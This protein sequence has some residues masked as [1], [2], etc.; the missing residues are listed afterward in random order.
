MGNEVL[1]KT[2]ARIGTGLR[3]LFLI[4]QSGISRDH[5]TEIATTQKQNYQGGDTST[6]SCYNRD[7]DG[8]GVSQSLIFEKLIVRHRKHT[9]L[10]AK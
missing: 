8:A 7:D 10:D 3:C 9:S 1:R 5:S 4:S 2:M 6:C